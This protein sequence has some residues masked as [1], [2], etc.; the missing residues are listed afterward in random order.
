MAWVSPSRSRARPGQVGDVVG[1]SGGTG[2][3]S[4]PGGGPMAPGGGDTGL[5]RRQE[6]RTPM[7]QCHQPAQ[8]GTGPSCRKGFRPLFLSTPG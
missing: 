3:F 7:D 6:T 2:G 4:L 5:G 1:N 8:I